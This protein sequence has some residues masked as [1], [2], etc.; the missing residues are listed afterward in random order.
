[1][2]WIVI[3]IGIAALGFLVYLVKILLWGDKR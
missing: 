2:N 1:M 3:G